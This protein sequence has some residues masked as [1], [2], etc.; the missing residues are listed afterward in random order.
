M[1]INT[2]KI[3]DSAKTFASSYQSNIDSASGVLAGFGLKPNCKNVTECDNMISECMKNKDVID[4]F[5]EVA[6]GTFVLIL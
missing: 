3:F 5:K 6:I 4:L 2:K 1:N